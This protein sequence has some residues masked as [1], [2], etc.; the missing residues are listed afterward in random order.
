MKKIIILGITI[1]M[2]TSIITGCGDANEK[3]TTS[4]VEEI[5]INE[6]TVNE[7]EVNEITTWENVEV[8]TYL[9]EEILVED[10]R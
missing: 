3:E 5:T 1:M 2:V 10:I 8:E 6:I 7:I 4:N 9:T